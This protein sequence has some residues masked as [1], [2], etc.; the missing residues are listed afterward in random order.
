MVEKISQHSVSVTEIVFEPEK[1][2]ELD[3]ENFY[4]VKLF[5][6]VFENVFDHII[7]S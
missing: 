7:K 1:K 4:P 3:F 2:F 6:K 5:A